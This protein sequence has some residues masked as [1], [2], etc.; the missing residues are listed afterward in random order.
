MSDLTKYIEDRKAT[1][2][3]FAD[4]FDTGYKEFKADIIA[5]TQRQLQ[6]HIPLSMFDA[7]RHLKT[8]S[9]G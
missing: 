7:K 4:G 3:E 5:E 1:D 6:K 2:S 8:V 9:V